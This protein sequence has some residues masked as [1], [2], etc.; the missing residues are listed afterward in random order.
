MGADRELRVNL[1]DD[2]SPITCPFIPPPSPVQ[3][4]PN[5][6]SSDEME[7]SHTRLP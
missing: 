3:S 7:S 4:G 1:W 6:G 2:V 5:Q